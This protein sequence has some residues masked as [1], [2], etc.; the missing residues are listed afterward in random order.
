MAYKKCLRRHAISLNLLRVETSM[1]LPRRTRSIRVQTTRAQRAANLRQLA[2][3]RLVPKRLNPAKTKVANGT[4]LLPDI[5]GRSLWARRAKELLAAHI[6]DLGG[7]DNVSEGERA[8]AK[9]CA[10]LVTELERREAAFAR[11]GEVSDH[12]LAVYQTTVNTLRRTLEAIGLQRRAKDVT[13]DLQT[14][15]RSRQAEARK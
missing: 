15:L 13:P 5:D 7:D 8:L 3:A 14:Y 10:V 6:A 4:V 2:K 11:D 12:A 9:R 1:A